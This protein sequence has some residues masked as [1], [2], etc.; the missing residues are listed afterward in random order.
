MNK[1]IKEQLDLIQLQL[2]KADAM[3]E[4]YMEAFEQSLFPITILQERLQKVSTQ[5]SYLERNKNELSTQLSSSDLKVI[6]P[7]LIKHLLEK[8]IEAFQQSSRE[9]KKHLLQLL[10][11][12]SCWNCRQN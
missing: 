11:R 9:K 12:F 3:Q 6:K 4:K 7:D 8:Y 5:K 2:D 10:L 1:D